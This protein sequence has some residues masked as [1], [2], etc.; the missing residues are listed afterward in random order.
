LK[1][2]IINAFDYTLRK[3]TSNWC[4][5]YISENPNYI[6][7]NKFKHFV[8]VIKKHKMMN[9]F[10]WSSTKSSKEKLSGLKCTYYE[11]IQKLVHGL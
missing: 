5:N 8:N 7:L 2:Y 11:C 10:T 6:F 3:T 4:H 1:E 9:I